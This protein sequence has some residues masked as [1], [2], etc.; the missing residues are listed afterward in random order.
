MSEVTKKSSVSRSSEIPD[1]T[2]SAAGQMPQHRAGQ[3]W[4]ER[5]DELLRLKV[6]AI[7]TTGRGVIIANRKG[8]IIWANRAMRQL[9]GYSPEELVGEN[10]RIFQSRHQS[11]PFYKQLWETILSG[12][13]WHGELINRRK[14]GQLYVEQMVITPVRNGSGEIAHFIAIKQDVTQERKAQERM[15]LLAS[16]VENSSELIASTDM[17]DRLTYLNPALLRAIGRKSEEMLGQKV[18]VLYSRNN[19]AF[20]VEQIARERSESSVWSGE[21]LMAGADGKDAPVHLS[22]NLIKDDLGQIVGSVGI[23]RD[24]SEK[25]QADNKL[26]ESE[27]LFRQLAENIREVFFVTTPER[28]RM[29][30]VSPAYEEIFGRPCE[31]VYKQPKV[32]LDAVLPEDRQRAIDSLLQSQRGAKTDIEFRIAHP[33]GSIRW[34]RSRSYPVFDGQ[35]RFNRVVGFAEDIT[36]RKIAEEELREAHEKLNLALEDSQ[37]R[38]RTS[39][40]ITDLVDLIQCAHTDEQA[41]QIIQESLSSIFDTCEGALCLTSASRDIVEAVAAWGDELKTERV[42]SPGDCWALRRGKS[43]IVKNAS[44]PVRCAHVSPSLKG[45]HVC[46]P[47]MAQGE[48]LGLLYLQCHKKEW[49]EGGELAEASMARAV[50]RTE[51]VAERVSLALANLQLRQILRSQSVREPLT[52]LYNR[53]YMEETLDRELARAVRKNETVALAMCDLDQ[54]KKFNDTFGHEAG[55]L[56]LREVASILRQKIRHCDIACRFGGEE[57]VLILPEATI[58]L[59]SERA[60]AIR[61]EVETLALAY[62]GHT[63]GRITISTGVAMFPEDGATAEELLRAADQSL[64][65]AKSEGRDRVVFFSSAR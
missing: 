51:T 37:Q 47:L 3:P 60:E 44:S 29:I 23:A 35:G 64:Y 27:E 42:F 32:W 1:N 33:D 8:K 41:Y 62:R 57:F 59:A 39:E 21:C 13:E 53:R 31:E 17:E 6:E 61:K 26:R 52:G 22:T 34:I 63:L 12:E 58:D 54:F 30:Y 55:D 28:S 48:T 20:L 56:V 45:G 49:K 14:D 15:R 25:K 36:E 16:A 65:R 11:P 18:D 5:A 38:A 24:I 40:K 43:H 50:R 19:P 2:G 4:I 9:T 46:V 7:E 10:P